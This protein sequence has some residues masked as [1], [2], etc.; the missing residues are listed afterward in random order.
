MLDT[1]GDSHDCF[2]GTMSAFV[3]V[4]IGASVA[5]VWWLRTVFTR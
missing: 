4:W 2:N 3:V 5:T 1:C